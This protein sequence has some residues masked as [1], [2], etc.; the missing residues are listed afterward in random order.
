MSQTSKDFFGARSHLDS[1][2]GKAAIFR[3]DA[4]E[5]ASVGTMSRLAFSVKVLW[6]P[7]F[8]TVTASS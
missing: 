8:A 7:H 5:K 2:S 4:L 1:G 3:L 6:K